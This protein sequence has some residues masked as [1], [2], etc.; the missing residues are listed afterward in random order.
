MGVYAGDDACLL[1]D[2][3]NKNMSI[4][5]ADTITCIHPLGTDHKYMEWKGKTCQRDQI[6]IGEN[7]LNELINDTYEF[8]NI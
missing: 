8:W 4:L 5:M 7:K 3:C 1:I 2:L 6:I